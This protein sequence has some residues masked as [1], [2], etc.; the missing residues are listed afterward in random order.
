MRNS[1]LKTCILYNSH[2]SILGE[3]ILKARDVHFPSSEGLL[4]AARLLFLSKLC[5]WLWQQEGYQRNTTSTAPFHHSL[6]FLIAG[7]VRLTCGASPR[8]WDTGGGSRLPASGMLWLVSWWTQVQHLRLMREE[9]M[10]FAEQGRRGRLKE[11]ALATSSWRKL[12]GNLS[13][14]QVVMCALLA[15]DLNNVKFSS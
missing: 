13:E 1:L 12:V 11:D 7:L 5:L 10:S 15:K 8:M 3:S 14:N 9:R 4:K 2:N 6:L